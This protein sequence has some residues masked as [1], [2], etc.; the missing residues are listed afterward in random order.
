MFKSLMD[1]CTQGELDSLTVMFDGF[2][3]FSLVLEN[4]ASAIKDGAFDDQL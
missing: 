1:T 4:F 3:E 2:Y